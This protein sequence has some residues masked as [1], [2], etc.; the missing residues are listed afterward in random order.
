MSAS[1][2]AGL[3][4]ASLSIIGTFTAV[5]RHLVKHYLAQLVP[6][7]NGGHNLEGRVSR[8]EVQLDLI[9][10]ELMRG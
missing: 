2:W 4:V 6:D 3:I 9:L 10:K 7:N 5:I 8:I 1:A